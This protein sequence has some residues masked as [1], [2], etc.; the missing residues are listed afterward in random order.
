M[1]K[2]PRYDRRSGKLL[3]IPEN[4]DY[5]IEELELKW[6]WAKEKY[7]CEDSD[8]TPS[9]LGAKTSRTRKLY[10]F[11]TEGIHEYEQKKDSELWEKCN[12]H[13]EL[14]NWKKKPEYFFIK[15]LKK[16]AIIIENDEVKISEK[17]PCE[18]DEEKAKVMEIIKEINNQK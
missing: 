6:S 10:T 8:F 16:T 14:S 3:M 18:N 7:K 15:G 12:N 2:K 4:K 1:K 5:L 9:K 17:Y 11:L 13:E